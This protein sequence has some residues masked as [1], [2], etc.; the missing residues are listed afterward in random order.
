MKTEPI[1]KVMM[2]QRRRPLTSPRSAANTPSWQVTEDRT[3]IVVLTL[4]NGMFS[5]CVSCAHS[6]G[7]TARKVKYIANSAAKNM[8]SLD[9]HT[10]VPI[11]TMLGRLAGACAYAAGVGVAVVTTGVS[12]IAARVA[13]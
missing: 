7:L 4:A 13:S 9:S 1:K 8:S 10:M 2:N 3:R 6:S 5:S 11:E 12:Q